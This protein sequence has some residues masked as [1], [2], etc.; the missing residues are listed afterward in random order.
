VKV[1][2]TYL[3]YPVPALLY[4]AERGN[5]HSTTVIF[6]LFAVSTERGQPVPAKVARFVASE[7]RKVI[8]GTKTPASMFNPEGT[9]R[10]TFDPLVADLVHL[11]PREGDIHSQF[12]EIGD[13]LHRSKATIDRQYYAHQRYSRRLWSIQS[14]LDEIE[15]RK[16]DFSR[17][18]FERDREIAAELQKLTS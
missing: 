6:D 11:T 3:G 10:Q 4:D 16:H 14:I 13:R 18:R 2:H 7:M 9:K 12:E 17:E 1:H 8:D 5:T 15:E